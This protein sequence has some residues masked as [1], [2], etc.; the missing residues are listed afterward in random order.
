MYDKL[1]L[2]HDD[3]REWKQFIQYELS[4]LLSDDKGISSPRRVVQEALQFAFLHLASYLLARLKKSG[5]QEEA[6]SD[7]VPE[8]T[9]YHPEPPLSIDEDGF[10]KVL[11][12][13]RPASLD[14]EETSETEPMPVGGT[15]S[16]KSV[17]NEFQQ[18]SSYRPALSEK[19]VEQEAPAVDS[20]LE[21]ITDH[22]GP[23]ISEEAAE[24]ET[25]EASKKTKLILGTDMFLIVW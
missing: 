11:I 21:Q 9:P 6:A 17:P 25:E 23:L 12:A 22:Q 16:P 1:L 5:E 19:A 20:V 13:G 8:R 24:L 18:L 2:L 15:I 3:D 14:R 7:F 10:E 4:K